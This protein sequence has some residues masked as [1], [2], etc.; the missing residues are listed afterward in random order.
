M[1]PMCLIANL[2]RPPSFRRAG[3]AVIVRVCLVLGHAR[4]EDGQLNH[5]YLLAEHALGAGPARHQS[6]GG[7]RVSSASED[8]SQGARRGEAAHVC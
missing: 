2:A 6:R 5:P 1:R 8:A 4:L 3:G 7:V